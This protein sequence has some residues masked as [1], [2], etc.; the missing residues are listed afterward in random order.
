MHLK[1]NPILKLRKLLTPNI[2]RKLSIHKFT[3]INVTY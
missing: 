2:D 3:D 1:Y